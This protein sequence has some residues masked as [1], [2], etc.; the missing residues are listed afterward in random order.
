MRLTD[1]ISSRRFVACVL[2]TLLMPRHPREL[3]LSS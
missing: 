3:G 1:W 2:I